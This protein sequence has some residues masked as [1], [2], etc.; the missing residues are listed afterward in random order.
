M[1]NKI[2]SLSQ[3]FTRFDDYKDRVFAGWELLIIFPG[4]SPKTF[5]II[6]L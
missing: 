3:F 1:Q 6:H 2:N 4:I 5:E